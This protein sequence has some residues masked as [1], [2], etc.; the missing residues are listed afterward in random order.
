[1]YKQAPA[2]PYT[3]VHGWLL[4]GV[5][6]MR[7]FWLLPTSHVAD[8]MRHRTSARADSDVKHEETKL[9]AGALDFATKT[10]HESSMQHTTCN[11]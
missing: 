6:A 5:N 2:H 8:E 3:L 4:L 7:R 1:M 9:V 11:R 10:V